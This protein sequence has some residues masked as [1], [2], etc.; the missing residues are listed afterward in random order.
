MTDVIELV[1]RWADDNE[2]EVES[3][4]AEQ[5]VV[6]LPGEKKLKTNVSIRAGAHAVDFQ[7]FIVRKPDENRER[8]FQW[9]LQQ[10]GRLGGLSFSVDGHDDVYLNASLP[11]EAFAA[12][13]AEDVLDSYLGRF[14]GIADKS[15][16]ELLVLGFL[17]SMKREWAWRIARGESTRNLSAFEHLVSGE[18]NEFIGTFTDLGPGPEDASGS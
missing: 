13:S 14:L 1:R 6:I 15:F 9:L 8:F 12:D 16:N 7:A 4:S 5:A 17:T 18:D 10:N 11:P 2:V 3:V